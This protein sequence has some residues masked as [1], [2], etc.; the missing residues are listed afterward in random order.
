MSSEYLWDPRDPAAPRD[1][2]VQHLERLLARYR[3][4]EQGTPRWMGGGRPRLRLLGWTA[5]AAAA[6]AAVLF[7]TRG[8]R[9][10]PGGYPVEGFAGLEHVHPGEALENDTGGNVRLQVASL[11][12][13][14]VAT[15]SKL[16]IERCAPDLHG[17]FL[18][19]GRVHARIYARPRVFQIDT[20]AGL[21][22]DL[23][24]EYELEVGADGVA[25]VRVQ[26]G[27]IE[28]VFD[29]REVYVPAN[30]RCTSRP[31]VGPDLPRFDAISGALDDVLAIALRGKALQVK[32]PGGF[33]ADLLADCT[34][35]DTLT[36]WHLYDS[37]LS[38]AEVRRAV[39][40]RLR[41]E[42]PFP[43]G[44]DEAGLERGDR[45]QRRAWRESMQPAWRFAHVKTD[46]R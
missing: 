33:L 44:V 45:A 36:L 43:A 15:G 1:A 13:V 26:S 12:H 17:F 30:A 29:G 38:T 16:R 42:F 46:R 2:E 23:G 9:A 37:E 22:V 25:S 11:G 28:F 21:T 20:P 10:Q 40:E 6:V 31:G 8:E 4:V 19:H 34:E 7:L 5:A 35:E 3:H 27:Q 41:R 24:C 18:E 14:D 39:F 32:D